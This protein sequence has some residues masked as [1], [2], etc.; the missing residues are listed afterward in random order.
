MGG[1]PGN[2]IEIAIELWIQAAQIIGGPLPAPNLPALS[3]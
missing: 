3:I 2:E 1:H